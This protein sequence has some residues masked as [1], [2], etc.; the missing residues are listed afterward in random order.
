M[1]TRSSVVWADRIVAH[2]SW[3]GPSW[4]SSQSSSA[5]P[6][7]SSASSRSV[8]F[9]RPRGERGPGTSGRYRRPRMTEPDDELRITRAPRTW[10]TY[11]P[12]AALP[13]ALDA[14]RERGGGEVRWWV[15]DPVDEDTTAAAAAGLDAE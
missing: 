5:V 6:G 9:A 2:S 3:N 13:R 14:I 11:A 7:Y 12:R 10:L 8:S 1:L 4:S 15:S